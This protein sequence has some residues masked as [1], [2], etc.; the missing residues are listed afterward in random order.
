MNTKRRRIIQANQAEILRS[1][2]RDSQFVR[3][4]NDQFQEILVNYKI[5][6][7]IGTI[8]SESVMKLLYFCLTH[9]LGNQT[10]GEEY[11]GVVPVKL[12]TLSMQPLSVII[13]IFIF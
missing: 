10:L 8:S 13:S 5:K 2:Q 7:S 9:G 1:H 12:R 6:K 11:T 4:L 3:L